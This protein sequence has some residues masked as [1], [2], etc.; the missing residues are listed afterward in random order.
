MFDYLVIVNRA[1]IRIEQVAITH[2]EMLEY[3]PTV[4]DMCLNG[5]KSNYV[6]SHPVCKQGLYRLY[7]FKV[8]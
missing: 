3:R 2:V 4:V 7:G 5:V 6:K 1:T 8:Y